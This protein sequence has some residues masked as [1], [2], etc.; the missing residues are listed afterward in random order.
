MSTDIFNDQKVPVVTVPE[1]SQVHVCK[2][3]GSRLTNKNLAFKL[4]MIFLKTKFDGG[5]HKRRTN[6]I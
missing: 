6:K 2:N 1:D 4:V 3:I 5:R